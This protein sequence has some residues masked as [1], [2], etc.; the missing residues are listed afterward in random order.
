MRQLS[1]ASRPSS[2][3]GLRRLPIKIDA[4]GR[5][6]GLSDDEIE[7]LLELR[8][9]RNKVAHTSEATINWSDAMR[10]QNAADR[11][12]LRLLESAQGPKSNGNGGTP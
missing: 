3:G 8:K 9:L 7:S 4:A 2:T 6:L 1:D 5:A 10:F 11:L 12:L